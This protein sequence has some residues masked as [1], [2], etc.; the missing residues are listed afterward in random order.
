MSS[1]VNAYTNT[2]ILFD[3]NG[4][5]LFTIH[6]IKKKNSLRIRNYTPKTEAALLSFQDVLVCYLNEKFS[7]I[8]KIKVNPIS[9]TTTSIANIL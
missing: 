6:E 9:L 4:G 2:S 1:V 5:Q 3:D 8:R 7:N